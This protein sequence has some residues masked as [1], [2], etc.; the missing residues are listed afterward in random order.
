MQGAWGEGGD[1]GYLRLMNEKISEGVCAVTAQR[2][3]Y[4]D[5]YWECLS[6]AFPR[7][8]LKGDTLHRGVTLE[9]P[10]V[11]ITEPTIR[12]VVSFITL[13]W[14][15]TLW[16]NL[17]YFTSQKLLFIFLYLKPMHTYF[18]FKGWWSMYKINKISFVSVPLYQCPCIKLFLHCIAL[19]TLS[20]STNSNSG[21]TNFPLL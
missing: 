11:R 3:S 10:S 6:L 15:L 8:C 19:C 1:G 2:K 17:C 4:A 16:F 18:P 14:K 9:S 13:Y 21:K 7:S 12:Q 20:I 5:H